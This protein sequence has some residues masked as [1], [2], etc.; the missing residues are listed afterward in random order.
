MFAAVMGIVL[1]GTALP[2]S[3]VAGLLGFATPPA[4][5]YLAIGAMVIV[6]LM[7]SEGA[8]SVLFVRIA[9]RP[10]R[11]AVRRHRVQRHASRFTLPGRLR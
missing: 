9:R 7:L 10:R 2:L 3:P 11:P 4:G 8:K 5:L 6:Y 1:I